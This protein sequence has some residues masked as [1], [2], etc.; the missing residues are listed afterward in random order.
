MHCMFKTH[1]EYI[2]NNM[3][4]V[5]LK[6]QSCVIL[7]HFPH[8]KKKPHTHQQSLTISSQIPYPQTTTCLLSLYTGLLWTFSI[9]GMIYY[10]VFCVWIL[11]FSLFLRFIHI[12]VYNSSVQF[13]RSVASNSLRPHELQHT[14]PPCPSPTPGAYPNSCPLSW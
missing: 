7:E 11:S 5:C 10:V 3:Y 4:P 12:A 6:I 9:N 14:R 2:F 1:V 8:S 13:S